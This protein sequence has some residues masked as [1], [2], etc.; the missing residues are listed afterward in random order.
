MKVTALRAAIG[1]ALAGSM[2]LPAAWAQDAQR[3]SAGLEEIVVTATR[4]EQNLQDVPLAVIAFTGENLEERGI[5]TMQDLSAVAPNV[6]IAGD[7]ASNNA[8]SFVMRGIPN[9]GIYIDGIW[10]S[11]GFLGNSGPLLREFTDIDRIE[12]LRGPQGTLYGRDSTGG[13][14]RI[15]TKPPADEFGF[16]V[17]LSLGN[18]D[19][20]D[21]TGS[22]DLPI[23]EN[24]RTRF[25]VGS[26]DVEGYV[27]SKVTGVSTGG[28]EDEVFR[29]DLEWTPSDRV[30]LRV[31]AQDDEIISTTPRVQ[32]WI[33]PQTAYNQGFQ[34]GLAEAYD[35]ASGGRWNCLT[36]C[37]G[38]PGGSVG[39]YE[40]TS[41]ITVPNR[42]WT[43]QQS[44]DLKIAVTDNVDF[45]YLL[46]H[47]YLDS[48]IYNDWD[49]GP[50][51]FFIDYFNVEQELLSHEFQFSGG[52]DRFSWVG[53]AYYWETEGR[54]RNPSWSMR[55]WIEIPGYGEP[56]P[57]SY[58]NQVLTHPSCQATPADR[59]LDFSFIPGHPANSVAGWIVPCNA[60]LSP[61]PNTG[62]VGALASGA[63]PPAGDRLFGSETDGYALFGEVTIGLTER[64]DLTLGYRYHDQTEDEFR[65]D[66]VPG[67]SATKPE[68]TNQEW[69]SGGVYEGRLQPGS[70][71]SISFDSDTMRVAASWQFTDDVMLY[72][73]YT[74][75]FNAGGIDTYVDSLGEVTRTYDPEDLKNYEIGIRAD[76]VGGRLRVNPTYFFTEWDSIQLLLTIPDRVTGLD[77]TELFNQN[78]ASAEVQGVEVELTFAAT[79]KLLLQSNIGILD[80]KYT[81][82]NHPKVHLNTEFAQAPDETINLGLQYD[83]DMRSGGTFITRF[84]ATYFGEYWR[85]ETPDLRQDFYGVPRSAEA[86][87]VWMVNA[88]LTYRP[89][90]GNYELSLFGTNLLDEYNINSGFMHGIWQFDF[91]TVDRPREVGIKMSAFFN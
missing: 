36:A 67:Y 18:Y 58:I 23:G 73:G 33:E 66:L 21:I 45:E 39:E 27:T 64:F 55:E 86:G 22:L 20:R 69:M 59:G 30:S 35:I 53:G 44:V 88:R 49:A 75:G 65:F 56:Q 81:D 17:D 7:L 8:G 10:Q 74:E 5:T 4:R 13:A 57:F 6:V 71:D 32:T 76:L 91:G 42:Q 43:E 78:A 37:A 15:Y 77:L 60:T 89:A 29:A 68:R 62:F 14:I 2:S 11:A 25:T 54:Q 83:A 51:N 80:T 41:E 16:Q 46:G 63:R 24:L 52:N 79:D 26:Y 3:E 50:F 61:W 82:T 90:R 85:S 40:S 9:V 48:R 72:L 38:Y 1:A 28:F 87:D 47:T 12:V 19:R 84:D 31:T 34:M 70:T